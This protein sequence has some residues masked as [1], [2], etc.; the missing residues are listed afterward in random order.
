V[1]T[2]AATAASAPAQEQETA[3]NKLDREVYDKLL[4]AIADMDNHA[5]RG[6]LTGKKRIPEGGWL[7]D[8]VE[9]FRA[10]VAE[11]SRNPF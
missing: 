5:V 7:D 2:E 6:Y 10:N 1:N 11:F 9:T 4:D 3:P 8:H